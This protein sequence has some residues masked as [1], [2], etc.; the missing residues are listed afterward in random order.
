[1]PHSERSRPEHQK[2]H[3]NRKGNSLV[4]ESVDNKD[5]KKGPLSQKGAILNIK[6]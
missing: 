1:M 4:G 3:C 6:T 2:L 5:I